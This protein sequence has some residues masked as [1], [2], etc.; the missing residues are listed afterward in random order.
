MILQAEANECGIACLAMI[1]RA[2]GVNIGMRGMRDKFPPSPHGASVRELMQIGRLMN[3]RATAYRI[4]PENLGEMLSPCVV[5]MD[6]SHFMVLTRLGT[7]GINLHDPAEGEVSLGFREFANR[8]TGV[9]IDLRPSGRFD[10][11]QKPERSNVFRFL[12]SGFVSQRLRVSVILLLALILEV[13]FAVS[14]LLVQTFTDS[15]VPSS[16]YHLAWLL[17]GGFSLVALLQLAFGLY[18]GLLLSR[19]SEHLFVEWN[20]RIGE[21][22]MSLPYA[23]FMRRAAT[24][25]YSRFRSIDNIQRTVTT[26]FVESALDGI[27]V[28]FTLTMIVIYSKILAIFTVLTAIV[29]AGSR[30]LTVD[31]ARKAERHEIRET[32][33]QHGRLLEMLNAI[34]TIKSGG[35]EAIQLS[36]YEARTR[37]AAHASATLQ[38]WTFTSSAIAKFLI[39]FHTVIAIGLGSIVCMRGQMT[40]GMVIAY[41]SYSTQFIDRSTKVSDVVAD[42]RLVKIHAERLSDIVDEKKMVPGVVH[43]PFGDAIG[44]RVENLS[45][46]YGN[47]DDDVIANAS[48]SIEP[49]ECVAIVG[50]SGLGKSTL[51]KLMN[52]L[53]VP[54]RGEILYDGISVSSISP[55]DLHN[56]VATVLQDDQLFG[57]TIFENIASFAPQY[58]RERV[59][60]VAKR[61]EIHDEIMQMPMGYETGVINMGKSLSGG[62]KQRILLARALYRRP[63]LLFLDEATS[64]LD[65][66]NE[67]A[68][69]RAISA[70]RITRVIVAHRADTIRMA[71]RVIDLAAFCAGYASEASHV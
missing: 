30:Q 11:A 23:F 53:L 8:F 19:L 34:H 3:F 59:I 61:A 67:Q 50:R 63:R 41:V 26:K 35:M 65:S 37:A 58:D 17:M 40:F 54:K 44:I 33:Q 12:V 45:F 66:R 55:V 9:V 62:Q 51:M 68:I 32:S 13:L 31:R 2:H 28:V 6:V 60:E 70:L 27:G 52:G 49:G 1:F 4:D 24:D 48:F 21:A 16:D 29:Y 36:R 20:I 71:E 42:S 18:R 47:H 43:L 22:L 7:D 38:M 5:L 57:G 69:N 56:S 14:P 10:D 46:G 39:Q 25:V 64:H 15:V